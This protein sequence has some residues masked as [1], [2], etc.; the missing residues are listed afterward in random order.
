MSHNFHA[1][2]ILSLPPCEMRFLFI[3]FRLFFVSAACRRLLPESHFSPLRAVTM[4][5]DVNFFFLFFPRDRLRFAFAERKFTF[6][7]SPCA[8]SFVM[9]L[10]G[11]CKSK[12]I[13]ISISSKRERIFLCFP[14]PFTFP[15]RLLPPASQASFKTKLTLSS[16]FAFAFSSS[17]IIQFQCWQ[18]W[19]ETLILAN[20]NERV[21]WD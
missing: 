16:E 14:S 11:W 10:Y 13:I 17:Q 6:S 15:F 18:T 8:C 20:V 12:F 21:T 5:S 1:N 7:S 4:Y 9:M 19:N 2:D 3:C